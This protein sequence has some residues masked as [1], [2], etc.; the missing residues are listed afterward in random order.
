MSY[1]KEFMIFVLLVVFCVFLIPLA[2]LIRF[3][4][5]KDK[6]KYISECFL[7]NPDRWN[8]EKICEARWNLKE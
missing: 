1:L 6:E 4:Y 8:I 3:Q 7:G 5:L 2:G